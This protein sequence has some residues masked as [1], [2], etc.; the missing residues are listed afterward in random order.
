[1]TRRVWVSGAVGATAILAAVLQLVA[2]A[3]RILDSL[4]H[5]SWFASWNESFGVEER[6]KDGFSS[7]FGSCSSSA[8]WPK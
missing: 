4:R 8:P 6:L 5:S 2:A 7:A 3:P 1:M